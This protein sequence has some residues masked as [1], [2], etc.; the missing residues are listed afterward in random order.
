V[1]EIPVEHALGL[2]ERTGARRN[3]MKAIPEGAD[4]KKLLMRLR[5]DDPVEPLLHGSTA[6][7]RY[8]LEALLSGGR[9]KENG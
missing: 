8:G 1:R 3:P 7:T 4:D 5:L 6:S 9:R 2:S